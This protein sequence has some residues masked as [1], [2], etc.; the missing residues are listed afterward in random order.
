MAQELTPTR[1]DRFVNKTISELQQANDSPI[2]GYKNQDIMK[3]ENAIEKVVPFVEGIT[4]YVD[5]A[6]QKCNRNSTILAWD[7]SAAIYL[8]TMPTPFFSRLNETLRA[9]NRHALKP[10]FAF[11]KLFM[12]ALEKI[13]S[14]AATVWRA[15]SGDVGTFPV[16]DNVESWWS[17][18][19]C[20]IALNVVEV[21]LGEMGTLFAIDAIHGK[22][23]SEYSAFPEEQEVILM[24]GT[25]VRLK[26]KPI[27]LNRLPVVHLEE[28]R[29]I[30]QYRE[31]LVRVRDS[32]KSKLIMH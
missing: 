23:I 30:E 20:S 1:S 8:Y 3:L 11:L 6:K 21:Y 17:V 28:E 5:D 16:E 15:V 29:T 4:T 31:R 9:E 25:Y 13:P 26:S 14:K 32:M 18:N 10:W 19:S 7:E 12:S 27:D 22:N 2:D 24:P